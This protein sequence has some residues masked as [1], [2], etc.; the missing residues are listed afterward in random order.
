MGIVMGAK[1]ESS[2]ADPLGLLSDCHRRI[3]RFLHT[4]IVLVEQTQD[5][6][7]VADRERNEENEEGRGHLSFGR[8]VLNAE[9]RHALEVA[10]RYF[11]EA[12]PRHTRDEEE[13]LFPKLR[14]CGSGAASAA[15]EAMEALEADHDRADAGHAEVENLGRKWLAEGRLTHQETAHMAEVLQSLQSLY[16]NHIQIEDMQIF[17]LAARL[18]DAETIQSIGREMAERRGINLDTVPDLKLHCPTQ[19]THSHDI[20]TA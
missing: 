18:L 11:Q 16:Q 2:F 5:A 8:T 7:A 14:A 17:P 10:L 4:L 13:S 19:R 20:T 12:S 6:D 9:Q 1:P 3:K 15:L